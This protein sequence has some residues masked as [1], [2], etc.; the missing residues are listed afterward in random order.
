MSLILAIE[1]SSRYKYIRTIEA[2]ASQYQFVVIMNATQF[3]GVFLIL[4][5]LIFLLAH[6]ASLI[7]PSY[8]SHNEAV[9]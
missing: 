8:L 4:K 5:R 6:F 1:Q 2:S 9:D 7:T 3:L